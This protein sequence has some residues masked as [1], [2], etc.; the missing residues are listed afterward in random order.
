[1]DAGACRPGGQ[2]T[3][4]LLSARGL[5]HRRRRGWR[6]G[7][8]LGNQLLHLGNLTN[9]GLYDAVGQLPHTWFSEWC[10]IIAFM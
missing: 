9:L 5:E 7:L 2:R 10:G 1:M 3:V 4:S 6:V 8:Q